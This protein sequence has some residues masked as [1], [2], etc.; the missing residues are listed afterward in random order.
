M[1]TNCTDTKNV[2]LRHHNTEVHKKFSKKNI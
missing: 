2:Y 1:K